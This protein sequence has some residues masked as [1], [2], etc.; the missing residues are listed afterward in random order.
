MR[1]PPTA[2]IAARAALTYF[3]MSRSR[4][5]RP[6][7]ATRTR[8]GPAGAPRRGPASEWP[9]EHLAAPESVEEPS[10]VPC[11]NLDREL[12]EV[13]SSRSGAPGAPRC[14]RGRSRASAPSRRWRPAA[15]ARPRGTDETRIHN[16]GERDQRL[17]RAD[18]GGGPGTADVLFPGLE[19][20]GERGASLR[21]D[22]GRPT[23]RPGAERRC[24]FRHANRPRRGPPNEGGTPNPCPSPTTTS[25]P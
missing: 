15:F 14:S 5:R 24:S 16:E 1:L 21:V 25:A 17:V 13:G 22:R 18:V 11:F 12:A 23:I 10:A 3:W 8:S 7:A 4:R 19:R 2:A 20:E 9:A 6:C